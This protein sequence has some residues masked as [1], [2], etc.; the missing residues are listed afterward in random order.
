MSSIDPKSLGAPSAPNVSMRL[1]QVQPP[2]Q[3]LTAQAQV[4]ELF[5]F[6]S[7]VYHSTYSVFM[8]SNSPPTLASVGFRL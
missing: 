1:G 7:T 6:V 5:P 4:V 3:L 8:Y 2:E